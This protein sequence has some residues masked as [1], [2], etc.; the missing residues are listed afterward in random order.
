M[1][2]ELFERICTLGI[3]F[4]FIMSAFIIDAH[5]NFLSKMIFKVIPF[6]LGLCSLYISGKLWG[7]LP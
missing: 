3:G 5:K 2:F 7:I 1:Y 4:W 6:F